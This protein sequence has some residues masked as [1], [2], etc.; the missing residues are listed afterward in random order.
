MGIALKYSHLLLTLLQWKRP[1]GLKSFTVSQDLLIF[2]LLS[3]TWAIPHSLQQRMALTRLLKKIGGT[4]NHQHA[5]LSFKALIQWVYA[6][7]DHSIG[8]NWAHQLFFPV[9]PR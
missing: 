3:L 7:G 6:E 1:L 9:A 4:E 2:P 8:M 5:L